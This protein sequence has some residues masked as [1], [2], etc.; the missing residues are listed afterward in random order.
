MKKSDIAF[1]FI[2]IFGVAVFVAYWLSRPDD[3]KQT[4]APQPAAKQFDPLKPQPAQ[5]APPP[6][7]NPQQIAALIAQLMQP[8]AAAADHAAEQLTKIGTTALAPLSAA[9]AATQDVLLQARI[10]AVTRAIAAQQRQPMAAQPPAAAQPVVPNLAV[11]L[12]Q[13]AE[14]PLDQRTTNIRTFTTPDGKTYRVTQ[15]TEGAKSKLTVEI[16]NAAGQ[17]LERVEAANETELAR[18]HP[19]LAAILRQNEGVGDREQIVQ[20][21]GM[22]RRVTIR[23]GGGGIVLNIGGGGIFGN[24]GTPLPN[25]PR[26]EAPAS[27]PVGD[28]GA[29]LAET[30]DGVRV[31]EVVANSRAAA[32]GLQAADLIVKINGRQINSLDDAN[33]LIQKADPAQP[34]K[35]EVTRRGELV[36]L[37]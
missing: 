30:A 5:P 15:I 25:M 13:F 35:L 24:R 14:E 8:N 18:T 12:P 2:G 9:R 29:R 32:C 23:G 22:M 28:F 34:L 20:G 21:P 37:P 1:I 33:D 27:A 19:Q 4:A 31:I 16:S 3:S 26:P 7:V 6:A 17:P 36:S 10:D 11:P